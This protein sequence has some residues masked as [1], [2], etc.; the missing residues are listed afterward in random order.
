MWFKCDF[1]YVRVAD[2]DAHTCPRNMHIF[3]KYIF[4]TPYNRLII[5]ILL[6]SSLS[7]DKSKAFSKTIPPHS[8]IQSLLLQMRVSSPV[9]KVIQQLLTS[10]SP[11][12]K[13]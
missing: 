13:G 12:I 9:L 1:S 4:S 8:A 5:I 3:K 7:D 10:S 2:L 6:F 11:S